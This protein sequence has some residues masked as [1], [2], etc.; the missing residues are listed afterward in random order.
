MGTR[1]EFDLVCL[2]EVNMNKDYIMYISIKGFLLFCLCISISMVLSL[3]FSNYAYKDSQHYDWVRWEKSR[4]C[5][6][7]GFASIR[8]Q[9]KPFVI[10]W[11]CK[12]G[13]L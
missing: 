5:W 6:K 4:R 1:L 13:D 12:L 7:N 2:N 8:K 9:E 11:S 3:G 10:L